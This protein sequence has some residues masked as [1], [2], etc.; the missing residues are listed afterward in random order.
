MAVGGYSS[1]DRYFV[2]GCAENLYLLGASRPEVAVPCVLEIHLDWCLCGE[3]NREV[4]DF[5]FGDRVLVGGDCYCQSH[6]ACAGCLRPFAGA[7]GAVGLYL[8]VVA[9]VDGEACDI[10]GGSGIEFFGPGFGPGHPVSEGIAGEGLLAG[11]R[12]PRGSDRSR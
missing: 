7:A 6:G 8:Y 12:L 11:G 5:A 10:G 9:G 1:R 3:C 4:C 2:G